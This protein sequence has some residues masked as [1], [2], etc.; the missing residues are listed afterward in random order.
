MKKLNFFIFFFLVFIIGVSA[1]GVI[2]YFYSFNKFYQ[3]NIGPILKELPFEA[4]SKEKN[5]PLVFGAYPSLENENF[6]NKTKNNLINQQFDF[7]SANLSEMKL[8]YYEK[9][10][11][12]KEYPILSKGEEGSWWETPAGLYQIELKEKNHFSSIGHVWMPYS[13]EFQGNFFIHG[14]TYYPD[15]TPTTRAYTGGCIR[16]KTADA[17]DLYEQ[18]KIGTPVLVFDKKFEKDQF[19]YQLKKPEISAKNYL[20]IDLKSDFEILE[21]NSQEKVPIASLTKLLTALVATEYINLSKEITITD[22]MLIET[23]IR[24]LEK[25]KKYSAFELLHPLLLESSN[26]AAEALSYFLGPSKFIAL[27]NSKAKSI[28]MENS[29]FVDPA[30]LSPL[31]VSSPKDLAQLAKYLYFNRSFILAITKGELEN[32]WLSNEFKG[33]LKNLNF[34]ADDPNFKG[35]KIGFLN[36]AGKTMLSIFEININGQKRPI[37]IIVLNSQDEKSD[38]QKILTWLTNTY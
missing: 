38:T 1:G 8:A 29:F 28:G 20:V 9:G 17:K 31:N 19:S 10:V 37:A 13:L 33:K 16:L 15:G 30:G 26:E 5:E 24:R 22:K 25:G 12:L 4:S 23:S 34:F 27:M 7:I 11:L 32:A 6:F 21:K 2:G 35:G 36:E 18:V 14:E 3:K